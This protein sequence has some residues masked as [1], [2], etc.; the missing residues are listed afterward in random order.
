[1]VVSCHAAWCIPDSQM[2]NSLPNV[3]EAGGGKH[4]SDY[5]MSHADVTKLLSNRYHAR[6]SQH[7]SGKPHQLQTL[8]H[9]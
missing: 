3:F 2:H 4:I 8:Y 1:M 5:D 6:N 9:E 7:Q